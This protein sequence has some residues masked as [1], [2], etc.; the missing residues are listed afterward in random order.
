MQDEFKNAFRVLQCLLVF[1]RLR[2][3]GK[4]CVGI[5]EARGVRSQRIRS[6]RQFAEF[7]IHFA[8]EINQHFD[9]M[10]LFVGFAVVNEKRLDRF[11]RR[12]LA[13][14]DGDVVKRRLCGRHAPGGFQ[15][16]PCLDHPRL[17][18]GAE[19]VSHKASAREAG[20]HSPERSC[21]F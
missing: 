20:W 3:D 21:D 17:G 15:I 19:V 18:F 14:I 13:M 2:F 6:I 11:F 8:G 9:A 4:S 12:L 16:T 1:A 7:G 10:R 5:A